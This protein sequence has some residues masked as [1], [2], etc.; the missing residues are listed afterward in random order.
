MCM[1]NIDF[2]FCQLAFWCCMFLNLYKSPCFSLWFFTNLIS[3][4]CYC[5]AYAWVYA[6]LYFILLPVGLLVIC[7]TPAPMVS[8]SST[9]GRHYVLPVPVLTLRPHFNAPTTSTFSP[10]FTEHALYLMKPTLQMESVSPLKKCTAQAARMLSNR[11]FSEAHILN[12]MV[13]PQNSLS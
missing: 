3:T 5:F 13:F 12:H 9:W 6:W 4:C 7:M 1:R 11:F 8:S 10:Y 2:D